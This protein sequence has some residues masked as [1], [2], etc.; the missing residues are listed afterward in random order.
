MAIF[1]TVFVIFIIFLTL[2]YFF[3]IRLIN[4]LSYLSA[5]KELMMNIK[6]NKQKAKLTLE[7]VEADIQ[8]I[9]DR[10]E[11][12]SELNVKKSELNDLKRSLKQMKEIQREI[13]NEVKDI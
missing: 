13:E 1:L 3:L 6:A 5:K 2:L 9:K 11:V 10:I 12:A 8:K 4:H 7:M